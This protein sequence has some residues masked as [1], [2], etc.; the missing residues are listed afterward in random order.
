MKIKDGADW[1]RYGEGQTHKYQG[2]RHLLTACNSVR[3]QFTTKKISGMCHFFLRVFCTRFFTCTLTLMLRAVITLT[4]HGLSWNFVL[5][6]KFV[7][8]RRR[9]AEGLRNASSILQHWLM[10]IYVQVFGCLGNGIRS[11]LPRTSVLQSVRV[12]QFFTRKGAFYELKHVSTF[13]RNKPFNHC[14]FINQIQIHTILSPCSK[15]LFC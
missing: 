6:K 2:R 14:I 13:T 3:G 7:G 10:P 12:W 8:E 15:N 9:Y 5:R 4:M 11:F 1:K